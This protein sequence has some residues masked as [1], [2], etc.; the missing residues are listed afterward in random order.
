MGY[1]SR[2]E[3][4]MS[5]SALV[6][7]DVAGPKHARMPARLRMTRSRSPSSLSEILALD[8][9]FGKAR[10]QTDTIGK[11]GLESGSMACDLSYGIIGRRTCRVAAM[12]TPCVT[13]QA[14]CVHEHRLTKR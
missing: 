13:N 5:G 7:P 10:S 1:L 14:P 11:T 8:F 12:V 3:D 6:N 9:E 2:P 4:S